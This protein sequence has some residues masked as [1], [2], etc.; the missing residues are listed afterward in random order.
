M[1]EDS[2]TTPDDDADR[3]Q[4]LEA[5]IADYI[6]AC[7]T[8]L[9]PDRREILE[10]HP[11]LADELRQF[12]G[13]RDRMN[14][15]VEPMRGFGEAVALA[16][17]PGQKLN[18][19]GNYELLEEIARGGMGVVYKARQTTLGRIVAVK[20][21]VSG[22]LATDDD[23]RRFHVEAE[24]AAGLQHPNIV[25][26]HE[27]GQHE[28]FHYFSMDYVEGRD[29]SAILRENLLPAKQAATYVRQMAEAI[30]YAHQQGTL[31]RDLKPSNI[32]IDS[33]DQVRITDFGLAMRVE[34]NSDL[35]RTGQIVG[36]P[37]YMPPEQAQ[38]QRSLIG[39][40]S[41]V[42]SLG[43]VLYECLTGRAPFRAD[44]VMKT[45]EQVIH[46]EAASPRL[47]NPGIA[48]D[49]ETICLKCLQKEPH[50]RYGTAQLLA[51]DL[52]RFLQGQP[53]LAR[54]LGSVEKIWRKCRQNPMVTA[55]IATVAVCL[56]AGTSVSSYFA[57]EA[58][59]RAKSETQHRQTAERERGVAELQKGRAVAA[60]QQSANSLK[61]ALAAVE[62]MLTRVAQERL[63]N[64][65]QMEPVRKELMEDALKFYQKFLRENDNDP[66]IRRETAS[67]HRRLA[68]IYRRLGR[69]IEA[70][71]SYRKAFEMFEELERQSTLDPNVRVDL[72]AA[73][74]E[75]ATCYRD[76]ERPIVQERHNRIAFA[77]A[78]KLANEF[79]NEPKYMDALVDAA[80]HLSGAISS[81]RPDEAETI[82]RRNLTLASSD[83]SVSISNKALGDVLANQGRIS[84]AEPFFRKSLEIAERISVNE[85]S[86]R[87][88][89]WLLSGSLLALE[90]TLVSQ[91]QLEEAEVLLNRAIVICDKLAAEYPTGPDYRAAQAWAY[92]SQTRLL[93]KRNRM[94]EAVRAY[95]R[96]VDILTGLAADFPNTPTFARGASF[97]RLTFGSFLE[98]LGRANDSKLIYRTEIDLAE[99]RVATSPQMVNEWHGLVH[100]QLVLGSV[101]AKSGQT[102]EAEAAFRQALETQER[103]DRNFSDRPGDRRQLAQ[104]HLQ[105]AEFLVNSGRSAEAEKVCR[106]AVRSYTKLVTEFPEER[107][108]RQKLASCYVQLGHASRPQPTVAEAA[109]RD[110]LALILQLSVEHP[111]VLVYSRE[112]ANCR[113]E[114]TYQLLVAGRLDEAEKLAHENVPWAAVIAASAT[115]DAET[116]K[117]AGTAYRIIGGVMRGKDRLQEAE[118]AMRASGDIFAKLADE[119]PSVTF[120]RELVGHTHHDLA[121]VLA[122]VGKNDDASRNYELCAAT[123]REL[124]KEFPQSGD[125]RHQLADV[126][127]VIGGRLRQSQPKAAELAYQEGLILFE[128]LVAERSNLPT[129][130]AQV[131]WLFRKTVS[132][133]QAE[134]MHRRDIGA[135]ASLTEDFPDNPS[136][137]EQLAHGHR[138]WAYYMQSQRRPQESEQ[139]FLA[140]IKVLEK[141]T[142]K[143]PGAP[144]H[145]D[146]LGD[147]HHVLADLL[148]ANGRSD[149]A[150]KYYRLAVDAYEKLVAEY[151]QKDDFPDAAKYRSE[152][153]RCLNWR[154]VFLGRQGRHREA[155][156]DHRRALSL[157]EELVKTTP[158][159]V[160]W[161][162]RELF[163]TYANHAEALTNLGRLDEA[164]RAFLQCIALGEKLHTDF[165]T[166]GYQRW[167]SA[168]CNELAWL[169]AT[170]PDPRSRNP[171]QATVVARRATEL[172]PGNPQFWTTLGAAHYRA[173]DGK[174]AIEALTKS[175]ELRKRGDGIAFFFL[176]LSH[177]QLGEKET[178][179][180][181]Y[182]K[183]VEWLEKYK[184]PTEELQRFRAEAAELLG[185]KDHEEK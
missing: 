163:W 170:A 121:G 102:D 124:A 150:E 142:A 139:A 82:L 184:P 92:E 33:H 44:S 88:A 73:H 120:Y 7:E 175:M 66:L 140:A 156:E 112:A 87:L 21:I 42:Y 178:A 118:Q 40:G 183:G 182:D 108:L 114:L 72:T 30:H 65:P 38:G 49:L 47:L 100:A 130:R 151:G 46:V 83:Y 74:F 79:V 167:L 89:Q 85:P 149:D 64:I 185:L 75:V 26:I 1:S 111:D 134:E 18:Y 63:A 24:A 78:E 22:R 122:T 34:G 59:V 126:C 58:N 107:V 56:I 153:G 94:E 29:L 137:P 20:M 146:L 80:T 69:N 138:E 9:A 60:Q 115:A 172:A 161:P 157:Y 106:F 113:T 104:S 27:V 119:M 181:W 91:G 136:W 41:D 51:D 105:V 127:F 10:R 110:A 141:S 6:R 133:S 135:F 168:L 39:P 4:Q 160:H 148:A 155:E 70:E 50:R 13:Q 131:G 23:V 16:V 128:K 84:E 174:A 36:T 67:A 144:Y 152:L 129:Y 145:R 48:R 11:E 19:V 17:G 90:G 93:K 125:Y 8:G 55:L 116:R 2:V 15:M 35:T 99:K 171:K 132:G 165:P 117:T 177:Q 147:T 54:P 45:I 180:T 32:L 103:S 43:A 62:Q 77:I 101:F 166:Q 31:H 37:S 96:A 173:G 159:P 61:D 53:I 158:E 179:R 76:L 12:F 71:E 28:G 154:G 95:R 86:D 3:D 5:V 123:W 169:W 162:R 109:Y 98:E 68:D 97:H 143:F 57:I 164:I 81:I 25:S 14:Q 176:A 52:Q